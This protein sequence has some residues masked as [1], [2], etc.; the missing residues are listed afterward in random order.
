MSRIYV[1]QSGFV[2]T[3]PHALIKSTEPD[4]TFRDSLYVLDYRVKDTDNYYDEE[5]EKLFHSFRKD[6]SL[7]NRFEF[8]EQIIKATYR[9]FSSTSIIPWLKLQLIQRTVGYLHRKYLQEALCSVLNKKPKTIENYQYYRLL[10][11]GE[12]SRAYPHD[13]HDADELLNEYIQEGSSV[14][15]SDLLSQ[16]T[17]DINGFCDLLETLHTIFGR[18]QGIASVSVKKS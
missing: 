16:W 1:L 17:K 5:I 11:A 2:T 6:N 8:R 7:M 9:V 10:H 12:T 15:I 14:L 13:E 3:Q 4:L 18:R